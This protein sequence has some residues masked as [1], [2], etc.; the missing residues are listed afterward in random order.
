MNAAALPAAALAATGDRLLE[1]GMG[2]ADHQLHP[3]QP[4]LPEVPQEGGP[5]RLV[6]AVAHLDPQHLALAIGSDAHRHDHGPGDHL[7]AGLIPA[8]EVRR[9]HVDV[10]VV[11]EFQRALQEGLHLGVEAL[12]DAAHLRFGDAALTAQRHHQ[13]VHLACGDSGDV[14]LHHHRPQGPVD[15]PAG[16]QQR[17]EEAPRPEA[18]DAQLDVTGWRG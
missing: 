17:W 1:A 14:G 13:L 7:L 2:V 4:P 8:V 16:F 11:A 3:C 9:V 12:A 18:W 6:L 5:E 15:P 10:R